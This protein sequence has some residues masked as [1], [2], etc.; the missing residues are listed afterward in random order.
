MFEVRWT[1]SAPDD[2]AR[3]W[4][5]ADSVQR[6]L[7]TKAAADI[8]T[9]LRYDPFAAGESREGNLRVLLVTPVGVFFR[10]HPQDRHAKIVALWA[11]S[12]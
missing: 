4:L 7:I 2:L 12:S 11:F 8:E 9:Q 10:V 5:D 1:Q 3:V 6:H